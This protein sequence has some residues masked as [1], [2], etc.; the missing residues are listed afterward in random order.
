MFNGFKILYDYVYLY[1]DNNYEFAN[2]INTKLK[3]QN[4]IVE[5]CRNYLNEHNIKASNRIYFISKGIVIGYID[6][7]KIKDIQ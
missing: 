3:K 4:K 6:K 5:E 7:D 2:D 1:L